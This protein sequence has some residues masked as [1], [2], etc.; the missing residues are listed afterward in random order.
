MYLSRLKTAEKINV[1]FRFHEKHIRGSTPLMMI[2]G[3]LLNQKGF[4]GNL[5]F[6]F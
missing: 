5:T 6:D 2:I 3:K 4:Y 1:T